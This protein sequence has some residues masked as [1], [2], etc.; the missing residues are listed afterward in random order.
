MKQ[1]I[2]LNNPT[3]NPSNPSK[4]SADQQRDDFTPTFVKARTLLATTARDE[5]WCVAVESLITT[6]GE[7]I[8]TA[9][10]EVDRVEDPVIRELD[11][12]LIGELIATRQQLDRAL[13]AERSKSPS[14]FQ[15][16]KHTLGVDKR[17]E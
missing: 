6:I 12:A 11:T 4:E 3:N 7:Q 5:D 10:T 2:Q 8:A 9:K 16:I 17:D 13:E 14:L 15:V 1:P